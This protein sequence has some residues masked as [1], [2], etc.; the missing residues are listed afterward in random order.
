MT[1]TNPITGD[2]ISSKVKDSKQYQS[3]YDMI[4]WGKKDERDSKESADSSV[5]SDS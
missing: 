1:A 3:N 5:G 4:D 2:E